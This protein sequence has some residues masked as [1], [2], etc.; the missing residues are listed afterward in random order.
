MEEKKLLIILAIAVIAVVAL[1]AFG[2]LFMAARFG[3]FFPAEHPAT[4]LII[5]TPSK[6]TMEVLNA[7]RELVY[8]IT[9]RTAD[10]M[11]RNS[12]QQLAQ[13]DIVMLD[14]SQQENKEVSRALGEAL[15]KY[16]NSGGKLIT[17]LDSGIK[18]PN[19]SGNIGW[20]TTFGT[21]IPVECRL[22]SMTNQPGCT[23]KVT[24][25]GRIF[26]GA[27]GHNH[28]IMRGITQ[29]PAEQSKLLRETVLDITNT[30]NEIAYIED[31]RTKVQYTAITEAQTLVGKSIYFNYDPGTTPAILETTLDYMTK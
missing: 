5:G 27:Y 26:P 12:E 22:E 1:F 19:E 3:N 28:A 30:G 6:Y 21:I 13:Y 18:E 15:Q 16:V 17:V 7:N 8:P 4:M 23:K 29:Y 10:A 11:S 9:T 25:N 14:Q 31:A 20:K 24:L 2:F